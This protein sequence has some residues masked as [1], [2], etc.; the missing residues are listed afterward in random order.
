MHT[1]TFS[2]L[3]RHAKK[4]L[5]AVER[6]ET[7]RVTRRGRTIARIVPADDNTKPSW[8]KPALKLEIPGV[9]LSRYILKERDE[10]SQ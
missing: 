3:R 9:E 8:K 4:Y 1:A 10:S 6:G 7:V 5:D 2:E